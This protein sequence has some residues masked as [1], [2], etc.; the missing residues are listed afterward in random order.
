MNSRKSRTLFDGIR[1]RPLP[2]PKPINKFDRYEL[3]TNDVEGARAFYAK[4]FGV[5]FWD[6]LGL[7]ISLVEGGS[8]MRAHWLGH[9]GVH[10]MAETKLRFLQAGA[11]SLGPSPWVIDDSAAVFRDRLGTL[12]AVSC[13]GTIF[14]ATERV[15]WHML[16]VHEE[17]EAI[18]MYSELL[19]WIPVATCEG[20][21]G[22]YRQ[23]VFAWN[24]GGP[25]VGTAANVAHRLRMP[26]QWLHCFR[27]KALAESLERVRSLG[28]EVVSPWVETGLGD[29]VAACQDPQGAKFALVES[30]P[31]KRW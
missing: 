25:S 27:T 21:I 29:V 15:A 11:A 5:D 8:Q 17:S 19:G 20:I 28:G 26:A 24:N 31:T 16:V 2:T 9:I 4:L 14:E 10:D 13:A 6:D 3:R 22:R 30:P 12:V 1:V 18:A 23:V 7:D